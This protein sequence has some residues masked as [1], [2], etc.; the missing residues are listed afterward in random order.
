MALC[1][2]VILN[3]VITQVVEL[4]VYLHLGTY[5]LD[6]IEGMLSSRGRE[7]CAGSPYNTFPLVG[8]LHLL[9]VPRRGTRPAVLGSH[10]SSATGPSSVH[11]SHTGVGG[12]QGGGPHE[13]QNGD[14]V[15]G[16]MFLAEELLF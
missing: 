7:K 10:P 4:K 3:F 2:H 14:Y 13:W 6:T 8:G 5:S 1:V 16:I 12:R 15:S 11:L 9:M